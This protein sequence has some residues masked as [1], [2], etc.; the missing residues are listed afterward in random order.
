MRFCHYRTLAVGLVVRTASLWLAASLVLF[1]MACA[2]SFAQT[3]QPQTCPHIASNVDLENCRRL[4]DAGSISAMMTLAEGYARG[5]YFFNGLYRPASDIPPNPDE[6]LRYYMLAADLGNDEAL[7]RL[8]GI[9]SRG[10]TLTVAKNRARAEAYLNKAAQ[11]GS[12]WAALLLAQ[13]QEKLAPNKA[14]ESYLRVA[15]NDNCVAQMRLVDA[16]ESGDLVKKNLTQAYFWVLLA[17]AD[18]YKRKADLEFGFTERFQLPSKG[19]R[20][21]C[22]VTGMNYLMRS[23]QLKKI[24]PAKLVQA[25]EDAAT[26]W[27]KGES[28]KLLPAPVITAPNA[29]A[30]D[31]KSKAPPKVSTTAPP[32]P[33]SSPKLAESS[34]AP[35]P[36]IQ[37]AMWTQLSKDARPPQL[38]NKQSAE[39]LFAKA[40]SSVW[41]VIATTSVSQSDATSHIS[42]GS[43]VA[44]TSSRLLTNYHVVEG[45]RFVF[46][47]QG[48]KVFEAT[49]VARA[50][51]GRT[52][53]AGIPMRF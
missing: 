23:H 7:P 41:V 2:P 9:Y 10:D 24:L 19:Y 45:Q 3:P 34:P 47:K 36:A 11:F 46:V 16:Y 25:A 26:N 30:P 48:D 40:R 42:Q 52:D 33:K 17:M 28:E 43:A 49:V 5:F 4:A 38:R 15:R 31:A 18:G 1:V 27:T 39:E 8:I 35:G 32:L 51:S 6:S 14:L 50:C 12:E 13:R 29:A 22:S 37:T 21:R 53:S 44:I 20:E